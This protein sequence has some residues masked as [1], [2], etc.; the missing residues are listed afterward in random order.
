[1]PHNSKEPMRE[2]SI[3][4]KDSRML[5]LAERLIKSYILRSICNHFDL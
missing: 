3:S 4:L 2:K 5:S 1:M